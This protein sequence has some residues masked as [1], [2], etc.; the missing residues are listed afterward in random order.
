MPALDPFGDPAFIA[1]EKRR[2]LGVRSYDWGEAKDIL[3]C[4]DTRLATLIKSGELPAARIGD[5]KISIGGRDLAM[6]LWK[7]LG[8]PFDLQAVPPPKRKSREAESRVTS[9][10]G[11]G[12]P[13]KG[14]R[15]LP[16]QVAS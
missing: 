4:G 12:R 1:F 3:K 16:K 15:S 10:R 7:A 2:G 9:P 5:R 14:V 8:K 13:R 6:V 11:R